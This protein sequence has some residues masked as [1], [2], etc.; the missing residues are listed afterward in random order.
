MNDN[1]DGYS[2]DNL[3]PIL[4]RDLRAD[5]VLRLGLHGQKLEDVIH[6]ALAYCS[7]R[8]FHNRGLFIRTA[9]DYAMGCWGDRKHPRTGYVRMA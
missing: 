4:E 5:A 2:L 1:D 7:V 6:D 8:M 9:N 3:Q